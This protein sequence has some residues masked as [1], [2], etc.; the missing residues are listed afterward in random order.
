[1]PVTIETIDTLAWEKMN[2][3]LPCVVQDSLSG[4]MLMLGYM[5]Q[6]A[7]LATL[8]SGSLTFFSRR[9]Q[10]LW[11]KGETSGNTLQLLE[12][13][14]DCDND[15]L[16]AVAKPAGPTCHKGTFSCWETSSRSGLAEL[17]RL[18]QTIAERR[19]AETIPDSY[20]QSLFNAGVR[21]CAQK[22][23]EEGVEVA[24]AAVS[25]SDDELLNE[26][27]DLLYH[28]LVTLRCRHVDLDQVMNKLQERRG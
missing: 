8:E 9:R 19:D 26:S 7:L 2:G 6:Q 23:G 24:L 17:A 20:T 4:A 21:R 14:A 16:L 22:V 25:G 27:A 5:N 3:L 13:S 1:M 12:L 10:S 28:L 11:R 18:E 15:A